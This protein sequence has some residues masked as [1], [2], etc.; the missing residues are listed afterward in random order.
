M[1][2]LVGGQRVTEEDADGWTLRFAEPLVTQLR[3]DYAFSLVLA[4]GAVIRIDEPF[5]LGTLEE[6]SLV[7][8]GDV[9][10]E[11]AAALP[12]FNQSVHSVRISRSGELTIR[13][14]EG[15]VIEVPVNQGYENWLISLVD[16]DTWVGLPGGGVSV[17]PASS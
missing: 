17:L 4:D 3:I 2:G 1:L 12:L 14:D 7:P 9:T 5:D 6:T 13:F 11:V 8:P 15:P 16:G 10:H